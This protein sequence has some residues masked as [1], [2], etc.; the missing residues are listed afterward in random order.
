MNTL[1]Q[2]TILVNAT[3]A[4][5]ET[6]RIQRLQQVIG[7]LCAVAEQHQDLDVLNRIEELYDH[8]GSLEVTWKDIPTEQ[9]KQFML[10]AWRSPIGDG[11]DNIQHHLPE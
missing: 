2:H 3:N 11:S 6:F 10:Q 7:Y 8:K 9:E 5:T 4:K 1:Y